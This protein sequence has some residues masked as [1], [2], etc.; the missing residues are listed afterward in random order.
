MSAIRA[1]KGHFPPWTFES[2]EVSGGGD[3]QGGNVLHPYVQTEQSKSA[4]K[5]AVG[6][7]QLGEK[8]REITR[9]HSNTTG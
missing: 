1:G 5:L 9:I 7:R 4:L 8:S 2:G 3:V 6:R